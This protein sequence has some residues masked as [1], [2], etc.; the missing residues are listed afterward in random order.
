MRGTKLSS[1]KKNILVEQWECR[2]PEEKILIDTQVLIYSLNIL[3][4]IFIVGFL[5]KNNVNN[6]VK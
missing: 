2:E 4:L 1:R 6:K 5:G 3:L